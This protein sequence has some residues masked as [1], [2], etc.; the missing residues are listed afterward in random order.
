MFEIEF[1]KP[2]FS[3]EKVGL[4]AKIE[5]L[6]ISAH[7]YPKAYNTPFCKNNCHL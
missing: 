2:G 1:E 5:V 3:I 4:L 6:V 7:Y